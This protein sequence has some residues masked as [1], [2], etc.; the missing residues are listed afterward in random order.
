MVEALDARARARPRAASA[1]RARSSG[2]SAPGSTTARLLC[3]SAAKF[4]TVSIPSSRSVVSRELAVA[5]VALDEHDPVLDRR[6]VRPV[7]RVGQEVVDD[8][9]VVRVVL[10]PVVDEVRAD[11]AGAA[12]DE[13]SHRAEG[14]AIALV[15]AGSARPSRQCGSTGAPAR[16]LRRIACAGRG[17]GRPSSSVEIRRTRQS[18]P[19]SSKIASAKSAHVQSPAAARCQ[20]PARRSSI[21]ELAHGRSRGGRRT[22]GSRAGR[23]RRRPRR[24]PRRAGASSARSCAR[25]GRRAT[26]CGRP[27]RPRRRRPRRA[28][29][30]ARTRRAGSARR[31]RRTARPCG[32]R[33][34]SRSRRR[35]AARPSAAAFAVPPTFTAAA[36]CG[37][38][39]A[40]STSVH[41]AVCRTRSSSPCDTVSL[42][43]LR[44][45][46]VLVAQSHEVVVRERV[47][48]RA[49]E[50]AAGARDQDATAA[51]R[52]DRIGVLVLHRSATRGSF[53][54]IVC[55]S[56]SA[57]SYSAV[58]W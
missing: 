5:D 43:G 18:S 13:K 39:S 38:A 9:V 14:Y 20:M 52:A 15:E 42:G 31:T 50:L 40:P 57:G 17:A 16:S 47:L 26:T 30:C 8:D 49:A 28:A 22:S 11:E 27:T 41:A 36:P 3:D 4:T 32:R 48:E 1:C 10:E 45:V 19:A 53:Q 51:S 12:G 54:G 7:A 24:A 58:T 29:S 37:S 35:R 25:S 34:R 56:G 33:R 2:R 46:P 6:E 23:R 44:D 21:D 55:S